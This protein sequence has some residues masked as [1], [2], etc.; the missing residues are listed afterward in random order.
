[1]TILGTNTDMINR[2]RVLPGY[3]HINRYWDRSFHCHAAKILPGEYY[4]TDHGEMITTVLGSC[5]SAC[6]RDR[7]LGVGGMNHFMLPHS[8]YT[9]D[10]DLLTSGAR[11]GSYAMEQLI[12]EI[13]KHG[14]SRKNLE[15]K[16]F[17][18]GQVMSNVTSVG[19]RNISFVR[20]Y[21]HAER[22]PIVAED[23]GGKYPRRVVFFPESGAAKVKRLQRL[24]NDTIVQRETAYQATLSTQGVES[25]VELF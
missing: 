17:G 12:N 11:Y 10:E 21:L 9:R 19:A 7:K 3:Q 16:L 5:V 25:D 23:L 20:D 1:M 14:G 18:G 8:E 24:K 15:V 22:L 4:V 2:P 6:I 13:I